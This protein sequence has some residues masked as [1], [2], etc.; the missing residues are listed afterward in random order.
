[1]SQQVQALLLPVAVMAVY[2]GSRRWAAPLAAWLERCEAWLEHPENEG[3]RKVMASIIAVLI[4][5]GVG[6]FL[7]GMPFWL[8]LLSAPVFA[9]VLIT[10]RH[11]YRK[12]RGKSGTPTRLS[13][14]TLLGNEDGR[15]GNRID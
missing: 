13:R 2:L 10:A 15:E 12:T 3:A 5:L 7:W 14:A 1:M 4:W 6:V 8:A 11:Y 9:A